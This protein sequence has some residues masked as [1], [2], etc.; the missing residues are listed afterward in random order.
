MS[1]PNTHA[2]GS[3]EWLRAVAADN[4]KLADFVRLVDDAE[5]DKAIRS[6]AAGLREAADRI[7]AIES[8]NARLLKANAELTEDSRRL[9]YMLQHRVHVAYTP[10][11][12]P[13][14]FSAWLDRTADNYSSGDPKISRRAALDDLMRRCPKG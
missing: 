10:Q 11:F 14:V 8:E 1:T 6:E 7:A 9:E 3:P 5:G 4:E 2:L 12:Y 13:N